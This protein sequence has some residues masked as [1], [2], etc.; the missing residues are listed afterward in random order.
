[1]AIE[2]RKAERKRAKARIA[3]C[4]PSGSGKTHGA[5]LLAKGMGTKIAL[6]DTENSSAEMEAGKPGIPEF[7]VVVMHAPFDPVKY[8]AA[9]QAAEDA[10][11]DVIIIDSLTHAW[12]GSGGLLEKMDML[13]KTKKNSFAAWRE[14]TPQHNRLVE[15][16]LQSKANIIATMRTK[17]SY[18][19][20]TNDKGRT[21]VKKMGMEPVQR[22][23]MD[24]EFTLVF[25]IDQGSHIASASKDRTSLFDTNP[26]VISTQTG[27]Q[28]KAWLE[29]GVTEKIEEP[30]TPEPQ[31]TGEMVGPRT[32]LFPEILK[33]DMPA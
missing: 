14:I 27:E 25:D 4:G 12:A 1:M 24:Y 21:E 33:E 9:V 18:A 29:A 32:E 30:V 31:T 11:Y 13:A 8:I 7:D 20:D 6:I 2:F 16:I 5:L 23:G 22:E 10:G 28:I 3:L 17:T 26:V 15:A 19:V